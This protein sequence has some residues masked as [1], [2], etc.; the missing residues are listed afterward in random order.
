MSL[1]AQKSALRQTVHAARDAL[2]PVERACLNQQIIQRMALM[3]AYQNAGVVLAYMNFG[4]EFGGADW[5]A[6]VLAEGKRLVLPKVNR[7][8]QELDLEWGED[9]AAQLE[10]GMWGIAEPVPASCERLGSLNAVEFATLPGLAFAKNGSRLG[11]GGGFY[12]K[13]LARMSPHPV[14]V[15][16]AYALQVVTEIPQQTTDVQVDWIVT[17]H[18]VIECSK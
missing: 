3:P 5:A 6:R 1:A 17:E 12:D 2:T 16:P 18:E 8:T 15:A 7:A 10:Q 11:Y 14:L 9:L 13:L 4:S